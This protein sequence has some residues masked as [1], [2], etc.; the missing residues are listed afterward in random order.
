MT[1]EQI[2][3]NNWYFDT[4]DFVYRMIKVNIEITYRYWSEVNPA[5]VPFCMNDIELLFSDL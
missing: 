3:G 1:R 5:K 4:T 2:G